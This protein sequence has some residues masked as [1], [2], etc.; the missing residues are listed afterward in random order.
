MKREATPEE[1][2][3]F[4]AETLEKKGRLGTSE[5]SEHF[6]ISE[7]TARR[8]LREMA[9]AGLLQRVHGGALPVSPA[10]QPFANRYRIAG[11]EK[12][13][14]ARCASQLISPGQL[15]IMDGGTT[16]LELA[17]QLPRDLPVTIVTNSPRIAIE[18]SEQPLLEVILLGGIFDKRSQMMLGA[19]VLGELAM[20]KADL[21]FLGIHGL[22]PELGL[23]TTGFDEGTIKKAMM[24]AS[25]EVVALVTESKFGTG[26]AYKFADVSDLNIIVADDTA[27]AK[28]FS[29]KV[30]KNTRLLLT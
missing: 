10:G 28:E 24:D 29:K 26:A 22:H 11:D 23:T 16:N 14:L 19:H 15:V 27:V 8:D 5:L 25:A 6:R 17:R 20:V 18:T 9:S 7:D 2:Q 30:H 1:R 4:I 12:V 21:C 3:Q 13:R